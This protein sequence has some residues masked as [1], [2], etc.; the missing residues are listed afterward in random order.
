MIGPQDYPSAE[1][2]DYVGR[3]GLPL[4]MGM[5]VACFFAYKGFDVA[6]VSVQYKPNRAQS[7]DPDPMTR[8]RDA[9]REQHSARVVASTAGLEA[10]VT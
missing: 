6:G 3:V 9:V 7:I 8:A 4:A 5:G 10:V 2:E 1:D